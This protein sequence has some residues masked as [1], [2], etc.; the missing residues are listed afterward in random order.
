MKNTI[1]N[2]SIALLICLAVY[3]A[4]WL[5]FGNISNQNIVNIFFGRVL[6]SGTLAERTH[7]TY[8]YRIITP[9]EN[10]ADNSFNIHY[11]QLGDNPYR[12][13]GD[14]LI[15]QTLKDGEFVSSE[16]FVSW[17]F[18]S[19]MS[20]V[21]EYAFPMPATV[22]TQNFGSR[23][24]LVSSKVNSFDIVGFEATDTGSLVTFVDLQSRMLYRF[25][26]PFEFVLS[27]P[28]PPKPLSIRYRA[29]SLDELG[30]VLDNV[31]IPDIPE[32]GAMYQSVRV[33]NPYA[34]SGERLRPTIEKKVDIFFDN[35]ASK[36]SYFGKND[37]YTF[38][39]DKT[40][41]KY[42]Q[43]DVLEYAQ[44]TA[45]DNDTSTQAA[46]ILRQYKTAYD[47]VRADSLV[48]N[49]Y[50]LSGYMVEEDT[51]LFYFDYI[52]EDFPL[53]IP[54]TYKNAG[55]A[56]LSHA[57]EVTVSGESV[58]KYK[59][60]AYNLVSD[61]RAAKAA[62]VSFEK[63]VNRISGN[64]PEEGMIYN[65]SFGYRIDR[66]RGALMYWVFETDGASFSIPATS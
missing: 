18:I 64:D 36:L 51:T 63:A 52:V 40:V 20:A 62:T 48:T 32:G 57:I 59:K 31:F 49:E 56:S 10:A 28:V 8:P 47:F 3:Q 39:D 41:V 54:D 4:T 46:D 24:T 9:V 53:I 30:Y 7:F 61:Y 1:K 26:T 50:S 33:I 21:Y 43:N 15:A 25:S 11:T 37:V 16:P 19:S 12:M 14:E 6:A 58:T 66:N 55:E 34:P 65:V 60:L 45:K 22:F 17:D 27:S 5:W 44:Y 2:A 23:T 42:F 35:P 13:L 38:S 29:S